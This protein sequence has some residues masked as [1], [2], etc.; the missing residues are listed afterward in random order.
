MDCLNLQPL[1]GCALAVPPP[2]SRPPAPPLIQPELESAFVA[3]AA[4]GGAVTLPDTLQETPQLYAAAVPARVLAAHLAS[5][6]RGLGCTLTPTQALLQLLWGYVT[7]NTYGATQRCV[8]CIGGCIGVQ[9][10][11]GPSGVSCRRQ[12]AGSRQ[13]A[14]E[15]ALSE[16]NEAAQI[17]ELP[18]GGGHLTCPTPNPTL[19]RSLSPHPSPPPPHT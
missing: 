19:P 11:G 2:Y 14:R 4:A 17:E 9:G 15:G 7:R 18:G 12:R 1:N 10:E 3:A 13:G 5:C 6:C 8:A 16:V